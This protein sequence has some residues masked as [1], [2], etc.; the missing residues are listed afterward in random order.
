MD[1]SNSFD[2]AQIPVDVIWMD[3]PATDG[4]RYF[5]FNETKFP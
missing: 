4:K 1:Y 3:I 2:E 5:V